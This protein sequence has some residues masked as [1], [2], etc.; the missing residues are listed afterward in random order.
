M[1]NNTR[2]AYLDAMGISYWV[3]RDTGLVSIPRMNP[4]N[5]SKI[6]F[7][8]GNPSGLRIKARVISLD[9]KESIPRKPL[10]LGNRTHEMGLVS[11]PAFS[12][13]L[14]RS[15]S[16]LILIDMQKQNAPYSDQEIY[17]LLINILRAASIAIEDL[18]IIT[19]AIKVPIIG[20]NVYDKNQKNIHSYVR[21][22]I[23]H[24]LEEINCRCLW[25][26]GLEAMYFAAKLKEEDYN[27]SLKI[28]GLGHIWAIPSL[29]LL[30]KEPWRK[31]YVW[32]SMQ[33]VILEKKI[34]SC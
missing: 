12:L 32:K 13:L 5:L 34:N 29:K 23:I 31:A 11:L 7:S 27:K 21:S 19:T 2:K 22:V 9:K 18:E 16:N 4:E 14:F 33:R 25:L 26:L 10:T 1:K 3:P 6:F 15:K 28:E 30:L 20:K 24:Q 17:T 8:S